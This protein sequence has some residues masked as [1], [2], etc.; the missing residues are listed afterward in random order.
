MEDTPDSGAWI[1][2]RWDFSLSI[3][4]KRKKATESKELFMVLML[5]L[6]GLWHAHWNLAR[7]LRVLRWKTWEEEHCSKNRKRV[8]FLF[9]TSFIGSSHP[10]WVREILSQ[11]H[12]TPLWGHMMFQPI[13]HFF[14]FMTYENQ[15]GSNMWASLWNFTSFFFFHRIRT[16]SLVEFRSSRSYTWYYLTLVLWELINIRCE[17][18]Q[19]TLTSGWRL[20]KGCLP[21]R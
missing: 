20:E 11:K 13:I 6:S 2:R 15:C 5:L 4:G 9:N 12:W 14:H 8:R 1:S 3:G 16:H 17:F 10:V 18:G 7:L 21:F 19:L